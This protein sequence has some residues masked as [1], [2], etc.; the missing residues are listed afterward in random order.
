MANP[1]QF[2]VENLDFKV[3]NPI[4]TKKWLQSVADSHGHSI[5]GLSYIF[6]DDNGLLPLNEQFLQH[7]TLT[8]I[9]T[10][11]H[12]ENGNGSI[13][14]D[15]YI[16]VERIQENAIEFKV[17]FQVE[18]RRVMAHGMLHLIGFKDKSAKDQKSMRSAEDAAL[19]L[20]P[21]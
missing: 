8:D 18:L 1:V 2:F 9:I 10:F 6:V 11:P 17:A 13:H 3:P 20:F 19:A 7:D 5:G 4:K 16:S 21:S 15:I 14:G 12:D